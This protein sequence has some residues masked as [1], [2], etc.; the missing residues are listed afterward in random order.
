[1][2]HSLDRIVKSAFLAGVLA[3]L[4][5]GLYSLAFTEP[6]LQRAIDFEAL[7]PHDDTTQVELVSRG[8]QRMGLFAG[9]GLYGLAWALITAS[10]YYPLQSWLPGTGALRRVL[11]LASLMYWSAALLPFLKYPANPPGI[12]EA[13]TLQ[14]RQ[15]LYF[16]FI[17][18]SVLGAAL[19]LIL[20]RAA[21]ERGW[22]AG[23]G[24]AQ[25]AAPVAA[26]A[27]VGALL[28]A[29]MPNQHQPATLPAD[30]VD[31]FRWHS[32]LGL[33]LFWGLFAAG[34]GGL[35]LR[36][37]SQSSASFGRLDRPAAPEP[38]RR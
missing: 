33:T 17:A 9:F 7:R 8:T 29:V 26:V 12:G 21:L 5:V 31:S 28:L 23:L 38:A 13:E 20:V 18:L 36:A 16:G 15:E 11:L 2:D 4:V 25:W 30:L 24:R 1:V 6:L 27:L 34:F 3:A 14:Q 32:L 10:V 19:A 35:L 37:T 22:L